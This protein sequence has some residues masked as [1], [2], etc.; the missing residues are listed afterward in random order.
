MTDVPP[1]GEEWSNY[2]EI[3]LLRQIV[4]HQN[5]QTIDLDSIAV[6]LSQSLAAFDT[7][8]TKLSAISTTLN[9]FLTD[10]I[11]A[12]ETPSNPATSAV[13]TVKGSPMP[14]Q[15]TVDT[16]NETVTI[17]FVDDHGDTD[18]APPVAASGAA[19]V[20]TFA[21]DTPG[22]ATVVTDPSN[23]LQGDV[24]VLSEGT[25]NLSATLAYADGSPVLEPDGVTSFPDPAPVTVTV[26]AGL[27]V[28][29]AL[30]LS[31]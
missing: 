5:T 16:T 21:S 2:E 20:V 7:M 8:I 27:A 31:I 14:G 29:D 22:V 6:L 3:Q 15:I 1:A 25:A 30:V 24:S 23:P 19:L 28:G 10:W 17:G 9:T 18:A 12:N 11:A 13:L 4:E 26:S